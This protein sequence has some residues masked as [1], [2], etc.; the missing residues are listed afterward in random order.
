[1]DK[2]GSA[3]P[4]PGGAST[5]PTEPSQDIN[6]TPGSAPSGIKS[7]RAELNLSNF[8]CEPPSKYTNKTAD[9]HR[10]L[11]PPPLDWLTRTWTVT[12]S[13]L[14]MWRSARNVRITYKILPGG[15]GADG[16]GGGSSSSNNDKPDRI[17][18]LVEYEPTSSTSK[19][20]NVKG[21]DTRS[22][23]LGWDWRGKS[24][25]FFV[26]SHWEVLGWGEVLSEDDDGEGTEVL[27][28]WVVTWFAPTVFTKEGLDV[29]S[30]RE[31]GV[32]EETYRR[33]CE[34][35]E[36][37]VCEKKG[38]DD[39]ESGR[40]LGLSPEVDVVRMFRQDLLPVE[41]KLPWIKA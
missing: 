28:R 8:Y 14:A 17:D 7:T 5:Q 13:T 23:T 12:H 2:A 39:G 27:E 16:G 33:I 10:V 32:S 26:T 24:W 21:V 1:M 19:L 18:D 35:L 36:A 25:L 34:G 15:G 11:E 6:A 40:P 38:G 22:P 30:D 31:G 20:K 4:T 29:Y 37:M 3:A 41:I 9:T